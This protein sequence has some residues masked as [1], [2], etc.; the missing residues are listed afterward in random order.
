M[1]L[2]GLQCLI[3]D[4]R[5]EVRQK[6]MDLLFD[7]LKQT[8][9]SAAFWEVIYEIILGYIPKSFLHLLEDDYNNGDY[10]KSAME[11]V[12]TTFAEHFD[13][14]ESH[15]IDFIERVGLFVSPNDDMVAKRGLDIHRFFVQHLLPKM[16]KDTYWEAIVRSLK[17][18]MAS[19][20]PKVL[21]EP[22]AVA[23]GAEGVAKITFEERDVTTKSVNHRNV[24]NYVRTVIVKDAGKLLS[25]KASMQ[26]L[27]ALYQSWTFA[28]DFNSNVEL[29]TKLR[30][31]GFLSHTVQLPTL[32]N[33]E[34][35]ALAGYLELAFAVYSQNSKTKEGET[36]L[37]NMWK[38][39]ERL[40]GG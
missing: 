8:Q 17:Q 27:E 39:D 37:E 13:M 10:V 15:C 9:F 4:K 7:V 2:K 19:T 6:A 36:L 16:Q 22:S 5:P 26:L 32:I 38:Y 1:L 21:F 30:K 20:T 23:T 35:D 33:Q 12:I 28:R 18:I 40:T 29:R 31:A 34:R 24:I 3:L 11:A 25:L 14:L